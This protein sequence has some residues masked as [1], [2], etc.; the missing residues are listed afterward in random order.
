MSDKVFLDTNILIYAYDAS[1]RKKHVIAK[2]LMMQFWESGTGVISI[3]V[4]QEF[5][6]VVTRKI[7]NPLDIQ[8]A[9]DIVSDLLKWELVV[10]DG[11]SI[12]G[13]IALLKK[14]HFSF[15]D[16]LIIGAALKANASFLY[17]EDLSHGQSI[18]SLTINN[19]FHSL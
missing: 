9:E 1:A 5:F 14:Y 17:S 11:D 6:V 8:T 7:P 4:L 15:W 16:A 13:A 18:E 12:L 19:P 10:C 2:D 3:Q